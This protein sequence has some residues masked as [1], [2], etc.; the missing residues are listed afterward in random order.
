MS[1]KK[2]G[3]PLL[4]GMKFDEQLQAKLLSMRSQQA[5][6]NSNIVLSVAR[7]LLLKD[8]KMLLSEF[9]RPIALEKE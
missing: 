9:G 7:A 1:G 6:I 3:K 5:V 2:R 8:N 4:I